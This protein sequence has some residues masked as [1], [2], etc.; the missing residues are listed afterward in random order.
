MILATAVLTL[1]LGDFFSTFLYHVPEHVFGKYHLAVHHGKD[2]N[3]LKYS[4][5]H[6]DIKALINGCFSLSMYLIA[7]PFLWHISIVGICLG[8]LL[9]LGHTLWRHSKLTTNN[10]IAFLCKLFMIVTP[11]FHQKH[12]Y[13]GEINFG[14]IFT[15][16]DM[17]AKKWLNYLKFIYGK[18]TFN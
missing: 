5:K 17:P 10:K 18:T 8:L 4:L 11:E 1:I 7:V 14:D 9:G 12:H 13:K 2:S 15:F 6:K 16:Y 3:F